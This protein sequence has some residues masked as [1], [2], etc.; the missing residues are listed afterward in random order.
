MNFAKS[1]AALLQDTARRL[2]TTFPCNF[3]TIGHCQDE[4][5]LSRNTNLRSMVQVYHFFLGS[6][7]FQRMFSLVYTVYCQKLPQEYRCSVRK[8]VLRNFVKFIGKHLCWILFL[9][10]LQ[11]WQLFWR[12]SVNDCFYTA[13]NP[14]AVAYPF[15]FIQHL[16]PPITPTTV[17][18]VNISYVCFWFK[19]ITFQNIKSGISFSLKSLS[20]LC[21][22]PCFLS[23]SVLFY[24][25]LLLIKRTLLS[26]ELIK[27]FLPT[28]T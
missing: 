21:F 16:L 13:L 2:L 11:A 1:T 24:L 9:I 23:F 15:Y 28:L 25:L 4:Y 22:F 12:T 17:N 10:K 5:S 18:T 26:W 27:M 14:F 20:S 3:T 19:F 6:I 7:N 8:G